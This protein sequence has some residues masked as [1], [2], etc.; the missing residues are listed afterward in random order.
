MKDA[1][2]ERHRSRARRR[3]ASKHPRSGLVQWLQVL[4]AALAGGVVLA[5]AI[6]WPIDPS[7][8]TRP[9]SRLPHTERAKVIEVTNVPCT[10]PDAE[11]CLEASFEL[12]TGPKA[13]DTAKIIVGEAGNEVAVEPGDAIRVVKTNVPEGSMVG[14]VQVAPYSFND[15]ERRSPLLWLAIGFSLLVLIAGRWHGLRALIGLTASLA[16]VVFFIVPALLQGEQPLA[17]ATI[18]ALAVMFLTIPVAHGFGPKTIAA[19]FGTT[20]SLLL[21]LALAL[22]FTKLAHL[23][24][25]SGDEVAYLRSYVGDLSIQGLLLAG[26]VIG[27]LGV[28]DDVTVSQASTVMALRRA[29]PALAFRDLFASA[30]TVGRD[31]I[32]ATVNTLVLAYAGASLPILLV[33]SLG[34]ARAQDAV[35]SEAVASQIIA[36]LVGS[37]G[38]IAAVPITTGIAVALALRMTDEELG[39]DV[40]HAH[41]H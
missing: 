12:L 23:T 38:L 14:G 10:V 25:F 13:G 15:F 22:A 39:Q 35:N 9:E 36:T 34:Q 20:F 24:G 26:V 8:V 40:A 16:V 21:T 29:N 11:G 6:L 1:K 33:L 4:M 41:V 19:T 2:R 27:A 5:M 30:L 7:S 18:G 28:L 17:V 32:T 31:H 37:I 3:R